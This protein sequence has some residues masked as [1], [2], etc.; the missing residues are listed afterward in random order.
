MFE[1]P[2]GH[3]EIE[4]VTASSADQTFLFHDMGTYAPLFIARAGTVSVVET[5]G[6]P[7][8]IPVFGRL[9]PDGALVVFDVS[10]SLWR[11]EVATREL[12]PLPA[13]DGRASWYVFTGT[14]SVAVLTDLGSTPVHDTQLW[15]VDLANASAVKRGEPSNAT[16]VYATEVGL[17]LQKDESKANDGSRVVLYLQRPDAVESPYYDAGAAT[18]ITLSP[19]GKTV[20]FSSKSLG[21][22]VWVVSLPGGEP[23]RI[24]GKGQVLSFS[25]DGAMVSVRLPDGRAASYTLLGDFKTEVADAARAGWVAIP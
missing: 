18:S 24:S 19:D 17:V 21:A 11:Y 16:I 12:A 9:S 8:D 2:P 5:P 3:P 4:V 20:A 14:R 1:P 23:R 13:I 15:E 6:Q 25:P 22:G 7:T 10:G